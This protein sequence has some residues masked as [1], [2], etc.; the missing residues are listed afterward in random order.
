[1][2]WA[3]ELLIEIRTLITEDWKLD[4]DERMQQVCGL[5]IQARLDHARD[6]NEAPFSKQLK[7][8]YS[9]EFAQM[10]REA[11]GFESA[12][13]LRDSVTNSLFALPVG[14]TQLEATQPNGSVVNPSPFHAADTRQS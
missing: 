2:A 1:M 6:T 7:T 9:E 11:R 4:D 3:D 5:C 10:L 13:L 12:D 14:C 8:R